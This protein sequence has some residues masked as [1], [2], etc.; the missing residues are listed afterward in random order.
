MRRFLAAAVLLV[1]LGGACGG[2]RDHEN[3][4][5]PGRFL[6]TSRSLAPTGH[7]FAEPVSVR[8][9]A[10]LNR[11]RLDPD[12][13]QL[14]VSFLPYRIIDGISRTREDFSRFTRLTYRL[15]LRCLTIACVPSRLQSVLGAQEGR[16]ERRTFRFKPAR[17]VYDDPE[18]GKIRHLRRI[19]W[20]PLD[21]ISRLS[22]V[23]PV[24]Q[25]GGGSFNP[26]APGGEFSATLAPVLEPSYRL[27]PPLLGGL[28]FTGAAALLAL[29][30]GLAAQA[31]HRR[32]R[33]Q[34]GEKEPELS[35]LERA[36][37]YLEWARDHGTEEETREALEALAFALD[38]GGGSDRAEG[39]RR[40]AWSPEAPPPAAMAEVV[41]SVRERDDA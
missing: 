13:V 41:Q 23:D 37:A 24:V 6:A 10:V 27:P 30:A 20:P 9:D 4:P 28:L 12:R 29:P 34:A 33:E 11:K 17:L 15:R 38:G 8:I 35:P 7:L 22:A 18:T 19:W 39:V 25:S 1:L 5:P 14:R 3:G 2:E 32:R 26:S 21:A 40:L 16:G 31:L 36:L